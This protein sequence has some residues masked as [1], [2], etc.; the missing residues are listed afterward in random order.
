MVKIGIYKIVS[1]SEKIYIGQSINIEKRWEKNYKTLKCKTQ[2]K[3]YNSLKKYGR[4]I[5]ISAHAPVP[6]ELQE[7]VDYVI[8]DA[9]NFLVKHTFYSQAWY[10]SDAYASFINLRGEGNDRYHGGVCYTS[11]YNGAMLGK[12]FNHE[13]LYF[14][15]Y[16]YILKDESYIDH[17]SD[18]L[19][20]KDMF[21]GFNTALEGP[22]FNT[23]FFGGKASVMLDQLKE[24]KNEQNYRCYWLWG[25]GLRYCTSCCHGKP[26]GGGVRQ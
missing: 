18:I 6:L 26:S 21:F 13:K 24:I 2:T 10:S 3:L 12:Y 1:P 20:T 19:D 16:D 4:K 7:M 23:Y 14:V 25:N 15:N 9:N 11:F 22:C 17:I 8:Y 5:I